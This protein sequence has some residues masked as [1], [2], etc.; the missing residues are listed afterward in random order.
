VGKK[1]QS[2]GEMLK[3]TL[4]MMFCWWEGAC[5]SKAINVFAQPILACR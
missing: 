1:A 4:D 5:C 2:D 3:G